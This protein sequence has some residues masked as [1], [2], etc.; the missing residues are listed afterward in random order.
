MASP[1]EVWLFILDSN[2]PLIESREAVC[3]FGE[4]DL[5]AHQRADSS[6][7]HDRQLQI[8]DP[9]APKVVYLALPNS[10]ETG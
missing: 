10:D 6:A 3:F 1:L 7:S 5:F 8:S 4:Q 9:A 2:R